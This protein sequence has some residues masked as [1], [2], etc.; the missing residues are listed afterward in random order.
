MKLKLTKK[1]KIF[2]FVILGI[3]I[4]SSG[5]FLLWRVLQEDTVAPEDSEAGWSQCWTAE[6]IGTDMTWCGGGEKTP[7]PGKCYRSNGTCWEECT[8]PGDEPTPVEPNCGVEPTFSFNRVPT[9][10]IGPFPEDG[11]VV[12][13]YKSLLTATYRPKLTLKDPSGNST[14]IKMPSLDSNKRARVVTNIEVKE[15][16]YIELVKS[17]DDTNQGNPGCNPGDPKYISFG[18]IKPN[19]NNTCGSG[20]NGPPSQYIPFEK[21]NV[22]SDINWAKSFGYDIVNKGSQ[23]WAD[24]REWPGDYDFNDYF[25]QISYEPVESAPECGSFHNK[26]YSEGDNI[27]GVGEFCEVGT[28]S[29]ASPAFPSI[30]GQTDWKCISGEEEVNCTASRVSIEEPEPVCGDG[31]LDGGEQCELGNPTGVSCT[32]DECNQ[33]TCVCPEVVQNPDWNISK[34]GVGE[35]IVVNNQTYAKGTYTITITNVGE[36]EGNIDKVVDQLDEKVVVEY[37]NEIS[38]EG[39]YASGLIT[40]DLEG[41]DEIF[42][43]EESLQFTYYILVPEESFGTYQNTVTAYPTEG[44]NFSGNK[45]LELICDI[46]EG[47]TPV[48]PETGI[49]DTVLGRVLFGVILILIGINWP[50]ITKLNYTVKEAISDQRIR[51]FERKVAK[52]K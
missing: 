34:T 14:T 40:W 41:E 25:L 50:N 17:D 42:S 3:I 26:V 48:V 21:I 23:C 12:L 49:F 2:L 44:E 13:Y 24:W 46:E 5:G 37:L 22:S 47:G 15:G 11:K 27:W 6:Y 19:S 1:G 9:K 39:A 4:L 10:N 20:L 7:E 30:D 36:G 43:P 45:G 8:C 52:K 51:N 29:P 35:C 16:E 31:V 33:T 18:W 28:A 32:W 38:N